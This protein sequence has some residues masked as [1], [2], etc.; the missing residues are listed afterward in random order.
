MMKMMFVVVI[1][2]AMAMIQETSA[3]SCE[4]GQPKC[5]ASCKAQKCATGVCTPTDKP[6]NEQNC[7][8]S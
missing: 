3:L 6:I 2:I 4:G 8:C 5:E 7:I 1:V